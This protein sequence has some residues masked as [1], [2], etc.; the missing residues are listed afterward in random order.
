MKR[1]TYRHSPE[2]KAKIGAAHKGRIYDLVTRAIIS[3]RTRAAMA[4]PAVRQRISER[5]RA[6]MPAAHTP[7]MKERKRLGLVAAFANPD[8]RRKVSAATKLGIAQRRARLLQA[9]RDAWK[10]A[11]KHTRNAFLA[12]I[13]GTQ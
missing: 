9:L 10:G 11:D 8:L 12:E 4:A 13:R 6:A 7:E 3:E 1:G 5:T 2:T